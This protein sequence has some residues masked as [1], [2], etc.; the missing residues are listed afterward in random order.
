M[1]TQFVFPGV[2]GN[3]MTTPGAVTT[4]TQR[5][6]VVRA[7]VDDWEANVVAFQGFVFRLA[8]FI[9]RRNPGTRAMQFTVYGTPGNVTVNGTYP[10]GVFPNGQ[11]VWLKATYDGVTGLGELSYSTSPSA[12]EP[13]TWTTFAS[14]TLATATLTHNT[15]FVDIGRDD[16]TRTF[17]GR[18]ARVIVRNG[19]AGA[20]VLDVDEANAK[21][22]G[23]TSFTATTGQ[24]VTVNQTAGNIIVQAA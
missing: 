6:V 9:F 16:P 19:I 15:Q 12:V 17:A 21:A 1:L 5:E 4:G 24:P 23:T 2:V 18:I 20:V 10:T 11:L 14:T 22:V 3:Y 8:S 7:A 13:T